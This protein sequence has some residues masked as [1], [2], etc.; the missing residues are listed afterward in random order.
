MLCRDYQIVSDTIYGLFYINNRFF[1]RFIRT[2]NRIMTME[3]TGED[4]LG[5]LLIELRLKCKEST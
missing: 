3:D 4:M 1:L 5:K 2:K